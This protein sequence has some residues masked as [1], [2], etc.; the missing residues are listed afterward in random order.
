MNITIYIYI[1][2]YIYMLLHSAKWGAE[3]IMEVFPLNKYLW[4]TS[5]DGY[6]TLYDEDR[7]L[8]QDMR[9]DDDESDITN[10]TTM[11]LELK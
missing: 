7:D 10:P 5:T 9:D 2:I 6:I 11:P 3:R 1:Y 8:C 4:G